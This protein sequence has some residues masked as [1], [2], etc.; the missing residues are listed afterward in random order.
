VS[1]SGV[2][3]RRPTGTAPGST[4]HAER[5]DLVQHADQQ[6]RAAGWAAVT[7]SGSQVWNGHSGALIANA[8]KNPR[9]SQRWVTGAS[10]TSPGR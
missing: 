6:H 2:A 8:M 3:K 10:V 7:E 9:K 5:A 1:T 4:D